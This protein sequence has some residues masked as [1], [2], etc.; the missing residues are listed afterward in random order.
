LLNSSIANFPKRCQVVSK[1]VASQTQWFLRSQYSVDQSV[2]GP[3]RI[4][5]R[6]S[7]SPVGG[8]RSKTRPARQAGGGGAGTPPAARPRGAILTVP[9]A[10]ASPVGVALRRAV[11]PPRRGGGARATPL[12]NTISPSPSEPSRRCCLPLF[13]SIAHVKTSAE[14]AVIPSP[15]L[16]EMLRGDCDHSFDG[17]GIRGFDQNV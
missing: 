5:E 17:K 12:R 14:A 16:R 4:A 11:P 8:F 1:T 13:C 6:M 10:V 9:A 3:N 2:C 15:A 7:T